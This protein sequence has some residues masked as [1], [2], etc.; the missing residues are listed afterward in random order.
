MFVILVLC[1][2]LGVAIGIFRVVAGGGVLK[3]E[4]MKSPV[5]T[6]KTYTY[7]GRIWSIGR[8]V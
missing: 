7:T 2:A 6:V 1:A 8:E 4:A 3:E 5:G